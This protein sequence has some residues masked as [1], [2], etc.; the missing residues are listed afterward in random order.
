MSFK[1]SH[2]Q[3]I[4]SQSFFSVLLLPVAL[5]KV[6]KAAVLFVILTQMHPTRQWNHR[7]I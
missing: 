2:T 3:T 7:I 1:N 5:D 6:C 4:L